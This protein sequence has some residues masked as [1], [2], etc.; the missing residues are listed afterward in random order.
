MLP[1]ML[2]DLLALLDKPLLVLIVMT[3]GGVIGIALENALNRADREK[4]K[5]YWR[6]RNAAKGK[7]GAS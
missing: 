2:A 7:V 5:A 3:V 1:A 6:G 4:R